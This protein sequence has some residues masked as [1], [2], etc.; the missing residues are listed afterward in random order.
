MK[1]Q[2]KFVFNYLDADKSGKMSK[3]ELKSAMAMMGMQSSDSAIA[4]MISTS[5]KDKDGLV[6]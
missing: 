1:D 5:D 6:S 2:Y 3:T 4:N